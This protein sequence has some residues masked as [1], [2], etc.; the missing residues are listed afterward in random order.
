MRRIYLV[1]SLYAT[2]N[3]FQNSDPPALLRV[4]KFRKFSNYP[5]NP[6]STKIESW[7]LKNPLYSFFCCCWSYSHI[8]VLFK[9]VFFLECLKIPFWSVLSSNC[10]RLHKK[11]T[12]YTRS[13][14]RSVKMINI[15]WFLVP[16]FLL[17]S[18]QSYKRLKL[19]TFM[20]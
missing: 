14:F 19:E 13:K 3:I 7:L 8:K 15:S 2:S 9:S 5:V 1:F 4:L 6:K 10:C 20:E 16:H 18:V 17:L 11:Y 12:S